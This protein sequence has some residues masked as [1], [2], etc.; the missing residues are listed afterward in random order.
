[1][2]SPDPGGAPVQ[3]PAGGLVRGVTLHHG[4][5]TGSLLRLEVPLSFWGGTDRRCRVVDR[6]HPAYG[7][8]LAGRVLAMPASRGSSSS[9][10]VLAEQVRAGCAPAALLLTEPDAIVVLGIMVAAELYGRDVP[11]VLL[12]GPDHGRL[13]AGRTVTVRADPDGAVVSW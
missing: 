10:S 8:D 12:S 3:R 5:G 13:P 1:M 2:S 7:T 11:V 4:T 6:H 9:S